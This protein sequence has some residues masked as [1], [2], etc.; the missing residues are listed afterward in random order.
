MVSAD[1][2]HAVHPNYADKCDPTN[3]PYLNGGV[4]IKHSANQKYTADAVSDALLRCICDRAGA[5]RVLGEVMS[6]LRR[7]GT[8]ADYRRRLNPEPGKSVAYIRYLNDYGT[9]AGSINCSDRAAF[10]RQARIC[11]S[12][13]QR[14]VAQTPGQQM[15]IH[16]GKEAQSSR[17]DANK[18][19][20]RKLR[21][22]E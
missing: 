12:I 19:R 18:L 16:C 4:V 5:A 6:N 10:Q 20:G 13:G 11:R 1:N 8:V 22:R 2:A 21:A 17:A 14:I 7:I 3:R 15:R 9:M